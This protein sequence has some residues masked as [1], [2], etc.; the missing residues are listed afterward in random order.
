MNSHTLDISD[1]GPLS[2][3]TSPDNEDQDHPPISP[4]PPRNLEGHITPV[5]GA[6]IVFTLDPVATLE[7][8]ED[9]VATELA[10]QIP[11]RPYVGLMPRQNVDLP[12]PLRRYNKCT[13][14]LLSQGLPQA[15]EADG[16]EETMCVPIH[17]AQ[18]PTGRTGVTISPPLP[19]DNLYHHSLLALDL[20]LTPKDGDYSTCPLVSQDDL[21]HLNMSFYRDN[22]RSDDLKEA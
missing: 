11:R 21:W 3:H 6:Y 14:I 18:H 13:C 10:Q 1:N 16:A 17:P 9:P 19:W 20:R 7:A 22:V 12:S 15:S 5:H 8:L 2:T 4:D